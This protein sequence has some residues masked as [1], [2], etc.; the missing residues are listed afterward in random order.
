MTRYL[1]GRLVAGVVTLFLFVT[2]L[3]FMAEWLM[4]KR[5]EPGEA[6]ALDQYREYLGGVVTGKFLHSSAIGALPW[7]LLIFVVA[8]GFAFPVGHWLG[9]IAGW[10]Y[11]ATGSAPLTIAAVVLYTLFPPLLVFVL[12]MITSR[13]T[14]DQ[15]I[16]YLRTLY[17]DGRMNPDVAW[18]ML[19]TIAVFAIVAGVG[20]VVAM[21]REWDVPGP[22]WAAVLIAGPALVWLARGMWSDVWDIFL[23]LGLPTFAVSIL[24]VGEVLLVSKSTTAEAAHEDFVFT[25]RAKGVPDRRVRDHHVGRFTLLPIL[26]KLMVSIPFILVG[27]M[28]IELSF[29]WAKFGYG[30]AGGPADPAGNGLGALGYYVPGMSSTLFA[31]L[32]GRDTATVVDGLIIVGFVVLG[33]RLLLDMATVILDPRI[34]VGNRA[35]P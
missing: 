10:K 24:A 22:V 34:R 15:G 20:A 18:S 4:P 27:L 31:A 33:F 12:I 19:L 25:A 26:S 11:G 13:F 30:D 8:I 5:V 23:Y 28:I 29:G 6:G 7:T 21:R 17:N 3:F 14:N 35:A 9:K 2:V 32:G 16:G 1:A